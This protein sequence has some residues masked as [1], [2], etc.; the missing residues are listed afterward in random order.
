[1]YVIK[2]TL[3]DTVYVKRNIVIFYESN[4]TMRL[5]RMKKEIVINLGELS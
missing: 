4:I 1:M 3:N 2:I 5:D